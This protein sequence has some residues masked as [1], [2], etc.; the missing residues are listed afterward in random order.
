MPKNSINYAQT[1]IYKLVCND[2]DVVEVYVG[3][4]TNFIKRK[5]NH[6]SKCHNPESDRHNLYIYQFIRA[7]GG[8]NNWKM[9]EIE[10]Y[11]CNN[12][13]EACRRERHYVELFHATLNTNI[14]SRTMREYYEDNKESLL[15]SNKKYYDDNAESLRK[16]SRDY[17]HKHKEERHDYRRAYY[18]NNKSVLQAKHRVYYEK[19]KERIIQQKLKSSLANVVVNLH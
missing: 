6:K 4:T 10:K 13:Q 12:E 11:P 5:A 14:P 2:I 19:N 9:I 8:F 18:S 16:H 7:N 3:H 17:Y 1:I 15:A